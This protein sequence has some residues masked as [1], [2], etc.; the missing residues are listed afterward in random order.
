VNLISNT[1]MEDP[2]SP[3]PAPGRALLECLL[4]DLS[5][6]TTEEKRQHA[7]SEWQ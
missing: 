5:F 2:T 7:K 6:D 3:S 4:C 1:I